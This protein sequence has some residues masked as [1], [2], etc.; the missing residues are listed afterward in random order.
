MFFPEI[1]E[2]VIERSIDLSGPEVPVFA[3]IAVQNEIITTSANEV[4]SRNCPFA[5]AEFL[6]VQKAQ[7]LLNSRYLSDA[8]IYVNLE[9]CMLC[10]A[11]LEKV[12]ISE[13]FFGAYDPKAGGIYHNATIFDHSLHKP[14]IIGG[15]QEK[16]CATIIKKFFQNIRQNQ[17]SE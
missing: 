6:C 2:H 14:K 8:S 15:I 1:F 7:R 9:P 5:H 17:S 13:I 16:R 12:R 3:A 11:I 10:S 4:E